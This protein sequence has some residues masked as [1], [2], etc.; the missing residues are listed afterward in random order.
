MS[1][2]MQT[3][4]SRLTAQRPSLAPRT[5]QEA[6]D[7]SAYLAKSELIPKDYQNKPHNIFV[8]VQYGMELGLPPMQA[9]QAIA[10][11]N[12]RP[13]MWGD[14]VLAVVMSHPAYEWHTEV[15]DGEGD[16]RAGVFTIKRRGQE[17]HVARFSVADARKAGLW[18]KSGPWTQHA[19]RMLKLRARGFA[20]RDKFPDALKGIISR[21]EAEDY[22]VTPVIEA[23]ATF[24]APQP[25][26]VVAP[27]ETLPSDPARITQP[28]AREFA[29]AWRASGYSVED[30]K[31]WLKAVLGL[32]S[33]LAIPTERFDEAITWARTAKENVPEPSRDETWCYALFDRLH[34]GLAERAEA[35]VDADGDWAG[36]VEHLR[37]EMEDRK[38]ERKPASR[39]EAPATEAELVGN[40][41]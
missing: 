20:L 28:Q 5:I 24:V 39:A 16:A 4:E 18:G 6:L 22:P 2:A 26:L 41:A 40:A 34:Y 37:A 13:S 27:A 32:T 35:I 9:L 12:G 7:F 1:I 31:A 11:I 33:S 29:K 17:E 3:G 30:A 8:A 15:V 38:E 10:V 25:A 14:A 23:R 36:L 21:E 19:D